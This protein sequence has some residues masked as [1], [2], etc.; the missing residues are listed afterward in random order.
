MSID[1]DNY[2]YPSFGIGARD[3]LYFTDE[4]RKKIDEAEKRIRASLA[5]QVKHLV[6]A[7][8][9]EKSTWKKRTSAWHGAKEQRL[10][11]DAKLKHAELVANGFEVLAYN[12]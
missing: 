4:E 10:L 8:D 11:L 9:T 6:K 5:K 3:E 1:F 2:T 12:E 7:P